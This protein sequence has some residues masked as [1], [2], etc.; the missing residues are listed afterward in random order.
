MCAGWGGAPAAAAALNPEIESFIDQL[1]ADHE[2]ER[3]ELRRWFKQAR[4]QNGVLKAISRPATARPWHE[5]RASQLT[6][7]R[8]RGGLEY[9]QRHA[10]TLARASTEYGVPEEIMVATIGVET[11]YGRNTGRNNVFDA[12]VTLAFSYPPRAGLFRGELEQFLLLTRELGLSPLR[13]KG[14]YAGALGVPQFLPSSYRR[15]AV[16]FDTNGTRDLWEHGDAIGSI[17]NYYKSYGWQP[18]EPVIVPIE[19]QAE[20]AGEEFRLLL[21]RGLKPHTTVAEIRRGGVTPAE[22]VAEDAL[23]CVFGAESE[24]GMR[25]WMGFNNFYVIT[26]YNRSVNYAL[27]VHELAQELRRAWHRSR[28]E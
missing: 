15:Y 10:D 4:V 14:S 25:Y 7:A 19:E 9:W 24:A 5:Y 2:F 12:L 13:F 26:R 18:G 8:I 27:A 16:D 21:E 11:F 22:P 23:I 1:V 20:T 3:S 6:E 17:A 28:S